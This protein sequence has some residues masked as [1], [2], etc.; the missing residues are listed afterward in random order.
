MNPTKTTSLL[1]SETVIV[2]E[3]HHRPFD[4]TN[5]RSSRMDSSGSPYL[6]DLQ[7]SGSQNIQYRLL[8][9]SSIYEMLNLQDYIYNRLSTKSL[10]VRDSKSE[11]LKSMENGFAIGILDEN[12]SII[13]YRVVSI[14]ERGD[15][16]RLESDLNFDQPLKKPAQLETTIILPNYRGNQL[17]Y[18]TL[19]IAQDILI[20]EKVT[21]MLCTVSPYNVF[22]LK[23]VMKAG[24]RINALKRKYGD[25]V[26]NSRGLWRFILYKSMTKQPLTNFQ[27]IASI[28]REK[29]D[30]QQI[31]LDNGYTGISLSDHSNRI[32]Y[33]RG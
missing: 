16:Q 24:L 23:N 11:I 21:D 22:S 28:Q 5:Q 20:Q 18:K 2:K 8:D 19:L 3:D 13:G 14:P 33:V 15:E 32:I 30:S 29:F 1:G 31:L 12:N 10:L 27:L 17:Q 25:K 7:K 6:I 4:V 9:K 26:D